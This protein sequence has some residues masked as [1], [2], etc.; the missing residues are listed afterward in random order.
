MKLI[1]KYILGKFFS[2]FI[3]VVLVLNAVICVIDYGEKSEDFLKHKLPAWFIIKNYYG[4]LIPSLT[5]MLSPIIVFITTI[6]VTARL[7][8]RTEIIAI[9]ASGVSFMRFMAP[10]LVGATVLGG[11]AFFS[12]GWVIPRANRMHIAFE[13]LYLKEQYYYEARNVH[14]KVAPN[15]FAYLQGYNNMTNVGYAFSLEKIEGNKLIEKLTSD[16]I[17]WD[18]LKRTWHV[19]RYKLHLFDGEAERI[20]E[21]EGL[22]TAISL[23]PKDFEST[24]R[25]HET[26][27][28]PQLNTYI[29]EQMARG[30]TNVGIFLVEKY[31]R[32]TYPFAM[33]ILTFMGVIVT[34]RKSRQGTGIQVAIGI[35]LAFLFIT[36]VRIFRSVGQAGSLDPMYSACIPTL[37]FALVA[38]VLYKTVPR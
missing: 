38:L 24:H 25:L 12:T 16:Q 21:G 13:L 29:D 15:T 36:L 33:I 4:N 32:F 11:I 30:N 17:R 1:D 37:T 2:T 14:F 8:A 27:T 28:L 23:R 18:T 35:A 22:D 34:A 3:Y 9:L 10:Y 20:R 6:F 19:D 5:N 31:E 26:L 7:S